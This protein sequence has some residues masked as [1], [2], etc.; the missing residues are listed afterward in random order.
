MGLDRDQFMA[1]SRLVTLALDS[2]YYSP[3]IPPPWYPRMGL[4]C[5][6]SSGSNR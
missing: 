1:A 6:C 3:P 5:L 2:G 4:P